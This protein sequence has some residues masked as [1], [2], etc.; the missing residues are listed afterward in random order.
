M[1]YYL[2]ILEHSWKRKETSICL[3]KLYSKFVQMKCNNKYERLSTQDIAQAT[4]I[5]TCNALT[6]VKSDSMTS[7]KKIK[8]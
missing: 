2:N 8:V 4:A 7:G 6:Y 5:W 3:I 1:E